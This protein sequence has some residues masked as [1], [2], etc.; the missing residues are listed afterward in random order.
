MIATRASSIAAVG[1]VAAVTLRS[2]SWR[3]PSPRAQHRA[4]PVAL[5]EHRLRLA[6]VGARP[7]PCG[8]RTAGRLPPRA[9][10]CHQRR[11]KCRSTSGGRSRRKG[12]IVEHA[13]RA[14]R[15]VQRPGASG[16]ASI[17]RGDVPGR[18]PCSERH[19][20][21]PPA[22]RP[23]SLERGR[24]RRRR[25]P[26]RRSPRRA[27]AEPPLLLDH[28]LDRPRRPSACA[29]ARRRPAP[30]RRSSALHVREDLKRL[31]ESTSP[32]SVSSA[33]SIS[34]MSGS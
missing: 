17:R 30:R 18:S 14:G 26:R 32:S 8:P 24:R 23:S 5:R 15:P 12:R 13:R 33:M 34:L 20:G 19:R 16:S 27:G 29:R 31:I 9:T 10:C 1:C 2:R 3:A 25:S 7:P 11:R 28:R 21:G 4:T 6:A 22:R